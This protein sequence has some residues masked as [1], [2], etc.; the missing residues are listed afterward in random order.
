MI[1]FQATENR[2]YP[3]DCD[4]IFTSSSSRQSMLPACSRQSVVPSPYSLPPSPENHT[5]LSP[6]NLLSSSPIILAPK[7]QEAESGNPWVTSGKQEASF[8]SSLSLL[9]SSPKYPVSLPI[10]SQDHL[11]LPPLFLSPTL[12]AHEDITLQ[13]SA[14]LIQTPSPAGIP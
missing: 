8:R 9:F 14:L 4:L 1:D 7:L 10:L 5:D 11:L 3:N 6:P 2:I 13:P 12:G